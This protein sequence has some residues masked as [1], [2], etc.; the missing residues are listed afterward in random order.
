MFKSSDKEI[1]QIK[2]QLSTIMQ[3]GETKHSE[4]IRN[5]KS[6][7]ELP[8]DSSAVYKVDL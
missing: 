4:F 2:Y 5:A 1:K 3:A 6:R 8:C 7:V